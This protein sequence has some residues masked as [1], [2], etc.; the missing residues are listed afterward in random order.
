MPGAG[1]NNKTDKN[2]HSRPGR[3]RGWQSRIGERGSH[4]RKAGRSRQQ[5]CIVA[6]CDT[7]RD[8]RRVGSFGGRPTSSRGESLYD[9]RIVAGGGSRAATVHG[10]GQGGNHSRQEA[11]K[12][13]NLQQ[14]NYETTN[15]YVSTHLQKEICDA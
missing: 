6:P 13:G 5:R 11:T 12:R 10:S 3:P 14:T 2:K 8:G 1:A 7:C 15:F 9:R 4:S